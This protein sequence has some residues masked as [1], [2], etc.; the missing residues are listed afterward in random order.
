MAVTNCG[1]VTTEKLAHQTRQGKIGQKVEGGGLFQDDAIG[2]S[3]ATVQSGYRAA[4]FSA[5]EKPYGGRPE[6]N[7]G[8]KRLARYPHEWQVTQRL[9]R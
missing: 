9:A 4:E 1:G 8:R 3:G 5:G 7:K 6:E 2:E